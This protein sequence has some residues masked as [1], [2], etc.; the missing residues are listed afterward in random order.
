MTTTPT[1]VQAALRERVPAIQADREMAA[2]AGLSIWNGQPPLIM[3]MT[4]G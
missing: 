2:F 3:G 4:D 1:D